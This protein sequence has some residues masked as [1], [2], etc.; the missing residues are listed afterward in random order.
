MN[1]NNKENNAKTLKWI[2]ALYC[3]VM[4]WLL[5]LQ[6]LG[7]VAPMGRYNLVP[8]DT[9]RL[10]IRL[11]QHS[12]SLAQRNSAIA[13]LAGNV[14]L[15]IP[16][17]IFIPLMVSW[18]QKFLPFVILTTGLLL[19]VELL[20]YLT[21]LGALVVDDMI[22]NFCGVMIGRIFWRLLWKNKEQ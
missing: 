3:I 18:Q 19:L 12:E 20:Q 5:F 13:N 4:I 6:R 2:F 16:F 9:V 22:L 11:L 10:Y 15:F 21:G 14:V 7:S 8:L 17:G 1:K